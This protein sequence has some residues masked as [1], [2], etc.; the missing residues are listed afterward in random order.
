MDNLFSTHSAT[1][2]RVKALIALGMDM[3]R[4]STSYGETSVPTVR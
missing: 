4:R 1:D 3:K 2:N